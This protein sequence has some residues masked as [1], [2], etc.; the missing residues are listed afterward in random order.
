MKLNKIS[1]NGILTV[2][3]DGDITATTAPELESALGDL[4][5]VKE[6]TFDFDKVSYISSAGLRVLLACQKKMMAVAGDMRIINCNDFVTDIFEIVG[7]DRFMKLQKKQ[8]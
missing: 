4:N 3:V 6:L 2:I 5:G 8:S 1:E 7:Y